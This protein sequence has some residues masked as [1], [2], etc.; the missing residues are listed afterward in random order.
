LVDEDVGVQRAHRI[1][2]G[3]AGTLGCE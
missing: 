2:V 1:C 3:V